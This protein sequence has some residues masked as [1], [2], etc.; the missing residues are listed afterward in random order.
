MLKYIRFTLIVVFGL[1]LGII[2]HSAI[3]IFA[4]WLLIHYFQNFFIKISWKGWL[5]IHFIFT[6]IIEIVGVILAFWLIKF[7]KIKRYKN[8][9]N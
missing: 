2:I 3:E 8:I 6:I 7:I 9:R 5:F 1:I 4:I